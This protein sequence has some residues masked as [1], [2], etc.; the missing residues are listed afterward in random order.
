V[1]VVGDTAVVIGTDDE[2]HGTYY[3]TKI[4]LN[5]GASEDIATVPFHAR[6]LAFDGSRF[7]T[8]Y[9]SGDQVVVFTLPG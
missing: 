3:V 8:N 2:E 5:S 6:G 7:W 4:D 1:V 9:R